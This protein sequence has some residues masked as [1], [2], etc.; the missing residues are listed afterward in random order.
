M[1]PDKEQVMSSRS[2]SLDRGWFEKDF[3]PENSEPEDQVDGLPPGFGFTPETKKYLQFP[4]HCTRGLNDNSVQLSSSIS[5]PDCVT[6]AELKCSKNIDSCSCEICRCEQ[7]PKH[8]LT[9]DG[10]SKSDIDTNRNSSNK[11]LKRPPSNKAILQRRHTYPTSKF[12][13]PMIQQPYMQSSGLNQDRDLE[14]DVI[15]T[16]HALFR[17]IDCRRL[18]IPEKSFF[19]QKPKLH[20]KKVKKKNAYSFNE[21]HLRK[22]YCL[23]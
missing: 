5:Q 22:G 2:L 15:H 14:K 19:I 21:N 9:K 1:F 20:K 7:S 6:K 23:V 13:I 18:D 4:K 16:Q 12:D 17:P 11:K 10:E 8:N 3:S